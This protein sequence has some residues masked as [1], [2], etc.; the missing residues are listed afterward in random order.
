MMCS[1]GQSDPDRPLQKGYREQV[2]STD[3]TQ[4]ACRPV[5]CGFCY[6]CLGL[7][8][9]AT[10]FVRVRVKKK[11]VSASPCAHMSLLFLLSRLLCAVANR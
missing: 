6:W 11:N 4:V 2:P 10:P 3:R 9:S 1:A 8:G 5:L 7:G